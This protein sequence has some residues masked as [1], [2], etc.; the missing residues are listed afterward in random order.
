[1]PRP[2]ECRFTEQHEWVHVENGVARI[3]ITDFAQG[4]LGQIVYVNMGEVGRSVAAGDEIG[5]V[6]SVKTVASV[7]A[8]VSGDVTQ[9]NG[10]LAEHPEH[11]NDDPFG[12]G[13]LVLLHAKDVSEANRLM[14]H[15]AYRKYLETAGH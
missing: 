8:P 13:W 7:Y 14:D 15:A 4:E 10:S 9:I 3:G 1:M 2:E 5:E 12:A 11:V 6:E